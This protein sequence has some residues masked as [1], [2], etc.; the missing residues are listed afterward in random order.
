MGNCELLGSMKHSS[1]LS[2]SLKVFLPVLRKLLNISYAQRSKRVP[3][4]NLNLIFLN[5][6]TERHPWKKKAAQ[7]GLNWCVYGKSRV[8][9]TGTSEK[10]LSCR[11]NI[12]LYNPQGMGYSNE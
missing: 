12:P 4:P 2:R 1:A 11:D 3:Y 5:R 9:Q 10:T 6:T 8:T 7:S